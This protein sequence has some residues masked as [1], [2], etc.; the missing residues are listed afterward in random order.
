MFQGEFIGSTTK[1]PLNGL[2]YPRN[3]AVD[4]LSNKLYIV[5]TGNIE[6]TQVWTYIFVSLICYL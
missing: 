5:E 6:N 1:L 3:L 4:W 2:V